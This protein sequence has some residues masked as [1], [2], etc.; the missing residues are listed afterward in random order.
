MAKE[1]TKKAEAV[2]KATAPSDAPANDPMALSIG[3]LK[4]L[5]TILDVASQ[6]GAFKAAEMANVGFLY[7]KLTAFLAKM[8]PANKPAEA[9]VAPEGK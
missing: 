3:D 6:R 8:D 7:N 9:P 5:S 1:D 4:N 2:D